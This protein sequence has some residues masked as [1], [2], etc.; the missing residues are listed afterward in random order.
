SAAGKAAAGT[1]ERL[2]ERTGNNIE[3]AVH[4]AVFGHSPAGFADKAGG[5][6][7]VAHHQRVVFFCQRNNFIH[8]RNGAVHRTSA[9]GNHNAAA[10][11]LSFFQLGFKVV[12]IVVLVAETFRFAQTHSVNNRGVVQFVADDGIFFIKQRLKHTTVGIEAGGV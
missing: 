5:V 4:P 10:V 11:L 7:L 6:A 1:A 3:L 12:H 2:A 8:L 9:V